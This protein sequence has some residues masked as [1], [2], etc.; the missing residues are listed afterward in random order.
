M[1]EGSQTE[2]YY[3]VSI[4]YYLRLW[5]ILLSSLKQS[6]ELSSG[7]PLFWSLFSSSSGSSMFHDVVYSSSKPQRQSLYAGIIFVLD[8]VKEDHTLHEQ[9]LELCLQHAPNGI[10]YSDSLHI[11]LNIL[12]LTYYPAFCKKS[13][14]K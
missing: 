1:S 11:N 5:G 9:L 13:N 6:G 4:Y 3:A 2:M 8:V 10:F 7:L 14:T 12:T